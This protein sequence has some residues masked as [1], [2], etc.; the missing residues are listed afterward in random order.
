MLTILR[1]NY[2]RA[3]VLENEPFRISVTVQP[4]CQVKTKCYCKNIKLK[5]Q[6][7]FV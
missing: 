2:Y 4:L 1:T 3:I 6:I 5:T 7:Q